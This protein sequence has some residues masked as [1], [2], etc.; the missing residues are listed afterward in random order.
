AGAGGGAEAVAAD[1]AAHR[2]AGGV[3]Q[4]LQLLAPGHR[5]RHGAAL[6]AGLDVREHGLGVAGPPA[7]F[8]RER[9]GVAA[10]ALPRGVAGARLH[11]AAVADAQHRAVV[12]HGADRVLL[13]AVV[14]A[15]DRVVV[16]L[17]RAVV[18][19]ADCLPIVRRPGQGDAAGLVGVVDRLA[20]A[21]EAQRARVRLAGRID[22]V[23]IHGIGGIALVPAGPRG[24][25]QAARDQRA[26]EVGVDRPVVAVHVV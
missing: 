13:D 4:C 7:A 8:V 22:R 19:E 1:A 20:A 26:G 17:A 23:G 6:V 11:P 3:P 9:P 16:L 24:Q 18:V 5:E 15:A 12:V 2:R 25:A 10:E 21:A 14:V